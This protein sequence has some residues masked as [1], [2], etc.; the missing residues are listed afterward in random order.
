MS[1]STLLFSLLALSTACDGGPPAT[2]S[3]KAAG[4]D[5]QPAG[6]PSP[7]APPTTRPVAPVDPFAQGF[8][9]YTVE[10]GE[11]NKG[12]GGIANV[13]S[14]HWMP[15]E[16]PGRSSAG[17][18]L[19][20]C[21]KSAQINI[22]WHNDDDELP[23]APGKYPIDKTGAKGTLSTISPLG[24]LAEPGEIDITAWD[25][26]HLAGTFAMKVNKDGAPRS[27]VGRF[28]LRCPYGT[29]THCTP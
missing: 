28:D 27:V 29:T 1:K 11:P 19:I 25:R 18:L 21:G 16:Q 9:E 10:G 26:S 4:N 7:A 8:C 22:Y 6:A 5:R 12:G 24:A 17:K 2:E 15:P 20:N 23:M 13:Q 3:T 14:T